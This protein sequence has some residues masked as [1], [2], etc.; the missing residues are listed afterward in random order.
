MRHLNSTHALFLGAVLGLGAAVLPSSCGKMPVITRCN[1]SNCDG[2]CDDTGSCF[3]G[4]SPEAC[5]ATGQTCAVCAMGQNCARVDQNNEFGG[6]CT[7][8]TTGGGDAG[9]GGGGGTTGG[10]GGTTGGGSATGGGGGSMDGG[11]C[12]A[13]TCA[14]GC[15]SATGVCIT[16]TTPSRCGTGGAACTSCMMGNTCVS[17]ACTPCTGCIDIS[18]GA[19]QGGMSNMLCGKMGSFCQACDQAAGQTCQGGTCFGGTTC[20][21]TTCAGCCDGNNCK[22]PT[23][24]TNAQCGQGAAG[25]ACTTCLNGATCDAMDAGACVGGGGM[26]GGGGIFPGLDGGGLPGMCDPAN[27]MNCNNGECCLDTLGICVPNGTDALIG[28]ACGAGGGVCDVCIGFLG[29]MC[30]TTAG[31]CN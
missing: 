18:T 5:G 10:G 3:K 1:A 24:Y 19:C 15:C 12:N 14:N 13:T 31:T 30:D 11:T 25:A 2:C 16:N 17:G 20:N 7:G 27:G 22:L 23:Q 28:Q 26:G 6:R 21:S 8:G 9:T 4:T 29:E